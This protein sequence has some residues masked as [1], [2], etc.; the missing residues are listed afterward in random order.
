[1]KK[2]INR[3]KE[4]LIVFIIIVFVVL[5][6]IVKVENYDSNEITKEKIYEYGEEIVTKEMVPNTVVAKVNGENIYKFEVDKY[7]YSLNSSD[8]I[9]RN[10]LYE[11]IKN[12]VIIKYADQ[13]YFDTRQ[14]LYQKTVDKHEN[15]S[16]EEFVKLLEIYGISE[17]EKWTSDEEIKDIML[18]QDLDMLLYSDGYSK[19]LKRAIKNEESFIDINYLEKLEQYNNLNDNNKSYELLTELENLYI[20]QLILNSNIE[21]CSY[22]ENGNISGNTI[23]EFTEEEKVI[24]TQKGGKFAKLGDIAIYANDFDEY[25]Y[26]FNIKEST[27]KKLYHAEDGIEKIYFDG[28]YIYLLPSYYRGK[29]I[30]KIDLLGNAY[31]I[32]EGASL[33]LWIEKDK[34]YFVDQIGYDQINGTPQGNL[35]RMNKDGSNKHILIQNVKNYFQIVDDYIYYTDQNSRSIYRATL[36]GTNKTEIAKGRTYITSATDKF[37]T[38]IDYNDNEKHKIIYLDN[39]Q[40]NT[41]GRFGNVY[42]SNQGIYLYQRPSQGNKA[43]LFSID[44]QNKLQYECWSSAENSFEYLAYIYNDYCYL[45]KGSDFY[46]VNINDKDEQE[47]MQFGSGT[48][49]IDGKAYSVKSVDGTI[50]KLVVYDLK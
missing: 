23:N 1:M 6:Q 45:R 49:F 26:I 44:V 39:N 50:Q 32:Y 38:Y 10:A 36:D 47:K 18:N 20:E 27:H 28:E 37:L 8:S 13:G 33:Q 48:C 14:E 22:I 40:I 9:Y 19:V 29:G 31:K 4:L 30:T 46:R 5:F 21:F 12:K 16:N 42:S 43:T 41:I 2:F 17:Q 11:T 3:Y 25:I 24:S 15:M 7:Q 35:Y 34:I